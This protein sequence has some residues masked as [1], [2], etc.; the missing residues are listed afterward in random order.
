MIRYLETIP[1]EEL[2]ELCS[3][4]ASDV[5]GV[6]AL[7]PVL[8]YG[9][10]YDFVSAWE[11]RDG[12]GTR[13]AF[14]S[15]Y[16]GTVTVCAVEGADREEL[17]AF[18]GVIGCDA[19]L[20]PEDLLPSFA[21]EGEAG[22]VMGLPR[23]DACIAEAVPVSDGITLEKDGRFRDFYDVLADS[24]PDWPT[25][26][27]EDFL[28]DLSHR[29]RHGTAHTAVLYRDGVAAATAAVLAQLP[30]AVLLGAVAT[31][32]AFRGNH[33]ATTCIR[34]LCDDNKDRTVFLL[35]RPEK[36]AFYEHLGF[37]AIDRYCE[38]QL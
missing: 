28:T 5:F 8:S 25:G 38:V 11:Q 9:T 14:L 36:Q 13:T 29:V 35:C 27:Y 22:P 17:E 18:F 23:G 31:R 37:T 33:C 4:C 21:A 16:Y 6:K 24:D 30:D 12:E 15:K 1:P 19:L 26:S 20:G 34:T 3:F 7:G 32:P 10:G 2:E